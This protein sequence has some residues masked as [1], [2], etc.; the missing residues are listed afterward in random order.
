MRIKNFKD[1]IKEV[2]EPGICQQCGGCVSFCNS[3]ENDVISMKDPNSP[4]KY[5]NDEKC[6]EC[7]IC[8]VICPQTHVL[9]D[10]LNKIYNFT[11]FSSMPSGFIDNI[12]SC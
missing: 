2:H 10:D 1:L 9:D 11:N 4:P 5:I 3:I 8:Y 7:E 6:L 12:Y